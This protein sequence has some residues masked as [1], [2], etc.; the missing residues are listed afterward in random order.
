MILLFVG[1][2]G[3]AAVDREQYPTTVRF[4]EKLPGEIKEDYVFHGVCRFLKDQKG[5]EIIDIEDVLETLGELQ[6]YCERIT[7][8]TN[9]TGWTLSGG[10][11]TIPRIEIPAAAL[12]SSI[13]GLEKAHLEP[14]SNQIKEQVYEFYGTHPAPNKLSAWIRLLKGLEEIDPVI[15]IF[16]TNYD[17]VLE[18]VIEEAKV[19]VDCG[20]DRSQRSTRLAPAFWNPSSPLFSTNRGLLTKLHGSVD[21]QHLNGDI[22]VAPSR[23]SGDHKNHCILYPGYKGVPTEEPFRAFHEHLRSVV[24]EEYGALTA[25]IFIGFAFRDEYINSILGELPS[26]TLA[27]LITKPEGKNLP[28]MGIA[29]SVPFSATFT[30][31]RGGLTEET[32]GDCLAYL[33]EKREK[34]EVAITIDELGG[35]SFDG[36]PIGQLVAMSKGWA[37]DKTTTDSYELE[38]GKI[39]KTKEEII[40]VFRELAGRDYLKM[41]RGPKEA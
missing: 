37:L 16:T 10:R 22:I 27:S 14:L 1:A 8:F 17:L 21:W 9:I 31:A 18:D 23:F 20:L 35:L 3:S 29:P 15:E 34:K 6:A 24:R 26:E 39:Y 38:P 7:D 11:L 28:N 32:V 19:K 30:H 40:A 13:E 36:T 12:H 2:G 4:F 25:A 41:P 33:S 5:K